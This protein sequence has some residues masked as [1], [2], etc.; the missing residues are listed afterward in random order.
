M[1]ATGDTIELL[2][3]TNGN[4]AAQ[5]TIS[6]ANT[7]TKNLTI[8]GNSVGS[9]KVSIK[10]TTG[11]PIT[12]DTTDLAGLITLQ[13]MTLDSSATASYNS[14]YLTGSKSTQYEDCNFI[15]DADNQQ[16]IKAIAATGA[17]ARDV[18]LI[19]CTFKSLGRDIVDVNTGNLKIENGTILAS[20]AG[21]Y[22]VKFY[23]VPGNTGTCDLD[24]ITGSIAGSMWSGLGTVGD[25]DI[26]DFN[27]TCTTVSGSKF[28]FSTYT[29]MGKLRI[30]NS[31]TTSPD[32][33]VICDNKPAAI[34]LKNNSH[35]V[36]GANPEIGIQVGFEYGSTTAWSPDS[37]SYVAGNIRSNDGQVY[38]CRTA[39]TSSADDEPGTGVNWTIYWQEYSMD[40]PIV[41]EDCDVNMVNATAHAILLGYGA[42][43]AVLN[44]GLY[45]N[46][47]Y[48]VVCKAKN[49]LMDGVTAYGANPFSIFAN[50]GN[51]IINC[52]GYSP[53]GVCLTYGDQVGLFTARNYIEKN[54]FVSTSAVVFTDDGNP[55][56][57]NDY[58]N[59]NCYWRLGTAGGIAVLGGETRD[60]LADVR[61]QWLTQSFLY[62]DN[63]SNS[64]NVNPLINAAGGDFNTPNMDLS[65]AG[66]EYIGAIAPTD[67]N[68]I[69]GNIKKDVGVI[70]NG[71]P[72]DGTY[73]PARGW[74]KNR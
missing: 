31:N 39:N 12:S 61:T 53:V 20:P 58:F 65:L 52:T 59:N 6:N 69:A 3:G 68:I 16:L 10:P 18:N 73:N 17:V 36:T 71:T 4:H 64:I 47:N 60:T 29:S 70:V 74:L 22:V 26:N 38:I 7:S 56:D 23:G 24:N 46:G 34:F 67:P 50:A 54:I 2:Y 27:I 41:I 48:Q 57:G 45:Q 13:N 72:I 40:I 5:V 8:H 28:D 9:T 14:A 32:G 66:G 21:R 33:G 15:N 11:Y 62:P 49:C 51:K 43:G 37:V 42:N 1:S 55:A 19:N 63:D 35:I 25:I 44:G 30:T